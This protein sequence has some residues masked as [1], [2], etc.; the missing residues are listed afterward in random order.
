MR[1][2]VPGLAAL[3]ACLVGHAP[4][5]GDG[6]PR[7]SLEA[8][9][10]E[11]P[12]VRP[13]PAEPR[14]HPDGA[15]VTFLREEGGATALLAFD[16]LSGAT[17][18]LLAAGRA[19]TP[20]A[21]GEKPRPLAL[22]GYRWSPDGKSLLLAS[23][24]DLFLADLSGAVR[25]LTH[26]P[27]EEEQAD[28]SPDGRRV[29]FVRKGDL[30]VVEVAAGR[31][32]RLTRSGSETVL[33]GRLDWVYEEELAAR[34]GRSYWWSPDS[35]S[36]AFLQL[37]QARVPTFPLVDFL[38]L[39]NTVHPQRYPKAGDPNAI[40]RVGV[41]G[42]G[43]DGTPGPERLLSFSPEDVYVAP[44]LSWS[45]DSRTLAFALLN[46]AQDELELRF[47]RVPES[48]SEALP[49]PRSVLTERDPAWVNVL[50]PARFL[51]DGRFLWLSERSGF[52]H[53]HLCEAGGACRPMTQGSFVVDELLDVDERTGFAYFTSTETHPRERQVYR[54]RLDGTGKAR[55]TTEGGTHKVEGFS[56]D[57]RNFVD[58]WS[59]IASPPRLGVRSVDARRSWTLGEGGP[60]PI[61]GYALGVN[62]WVELK[63]KDGTPLHARLL[64]PA[65]FDPQRR[66]PALVFVYGGPHAQDVQDSWGKGTPFE[67]LLVS[68]GFLLFCLDNRGTAGRGHAFEAHVNREMGRVELEDQLVGV[69]YLRSLPFV[70]GE[71]LGIWG[72]SYGGYMTLYAATHAP[73][74]FRAAVAGAP[75]TDWRF[76][77]SIYTERYMGRPKDN[78]KGYAAS[79]PLAAAGSLQADLLLVHGTADD[80]VHLANTVAFA[81]ALVKAGKPYRLVLLPGQKHTLTARE[82]NL[83]RDRAILE[84]FER[85]LR[86]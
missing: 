27:D 6:P 14:W 56:P 65:G 9:Y 47:L 42:L 25:R 21:A 74:V 44:N 60:E 68:R 33:N 69:E 86:P 81:D 11:V 24:G 46:R 13:L 66:Y 4:A 12:L 59:S 18:T 49:A 52:A 45:Q 8:L 22:K 58:T 10:G 28:F 1:R 7:L 17:S 51:R 37:D 78:P 55:V 83:A 32:A 62:E 63:A 85:L 76:Y 30:Y 79:S 39:H 35:R 61:Q 50:G 67:H 70:D 80:N 26:T 72:W 48:A 54:V 2:C 82:S 38:P 77:D 43:R 31:E 73:G 23:E 53:L 36:V 57:S 5:H 3:L 84:H 19:T 16:L 20:A 41:V 71:R 34:A 64:E 15:R 75:V 40:P 29:S